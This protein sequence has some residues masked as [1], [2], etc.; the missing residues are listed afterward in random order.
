MKPSCAR[1]LRVVEVF[2]SLQ[3]EGIRLGARQVFVRLAGCNLACSYCDQPETLRGSAGETWSAKKLRCRIRR[4][5]AERRHAAIAW[6]GGEPLLQVAGLAP[7]LRWAKASGW[8]NY[9]E[10]N[11]TLAEAFR[12]VAPLCD[13]VA[14]DIKLPSA[15]GRPTWSEHLEFLRVA[16]EKTF[17]KV[18]LTRGTTDAEWRRAVRLLGEASPDIPLV[19]QPA[20]AFGGEE[21][22]EPERALRFLR[23]ARGCLKDARLIPQWHPVWGVR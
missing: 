21:P 20:T 8:D 16:P 13:T 14:A 18:V 1:G 11:G 23:Q 2:S 5:Q 4:L 15:T 12:K 22:I 3:G 17:V 19:L 9:L 6:T 10:T 7:M